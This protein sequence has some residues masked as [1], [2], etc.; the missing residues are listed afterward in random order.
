[1]LK[2]AALLAFLGLLLAF[3]AAGVAG[4]E[5][6][7]MQWERTLGGREADRG[8]AVQPTADGGC[9][10]AGETFAGRPYPTG[11]ADALLVRLDASGRPVWQKSFGEVGHD[12]ALSV[13]PTADGGFAVTGVTQRPFTRDADALLAKLDA[14]GQLRWL[15]TFGEAGEDAGACV[16]QTADGGFIVAGTTTSSGAGGADIYLIKTGADGNPEWEKTFGGPGEDTAAAVRQTADGGFIVAGQTF[17][18]GAG[19]YDVYLVKTDG[20]GRKQWERTFGGPGWDLAGAVEETTDG[21]YIVVGRS[22]SFR[23]GDFD[24]YLVRTDAQGNKR[25]ELSLD[26]GGFDTGK[27]VRETANGDFLIAGWADPGGGPVAFYAAAV[28]TAGKKLWEKTLAGSRFGRE[29]AVQP[30]ADGGFVVAGWWAE[31][32]R[33]LEWRNDDVQ[34]YAARLTPRQGP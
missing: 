31:P 26:G 18:S 8:F 4:A 30:T 6:F 5:E 21:G 14:G 20:A 2:R 32:L 12:R 13:W 7:V 10:I 19:G 17:S 24:I 25:W 34:V 15:K 16:R 33:N 22:S 28:S 1:L 11:W 9:I 23:D 27:C 29:F 3:A